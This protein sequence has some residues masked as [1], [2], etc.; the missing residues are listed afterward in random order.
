MTE[1][2]Y[3]KKALPF[4]IVDFKGQCAYC[5]DSK[6]FRAPSQSQVEHFDCKLSGRQRHYYRN[7]NLS[8]AACN[9]SKHD[10]PVK[11]PFNPEQRLLNCCEENEYIGHIIEDDRGQW[12]PVTEAGKYHLAC[13]NL[14]ADCHVK[15]RNARKVM[16]ERIHS[17]LTTAI[18]YQTA[19]PQEVHDQLMGTVRDLMDHLNNFPP[20]VTKTGILTTKEWLVSR[21]VDVNLL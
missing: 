15:K 8:C 1:A 6:E 14:G 21:G 16:V 9:L 18:Q 19:N 11:N 12:L 4:L 10:K 3:R 2:T 20:I 17:L 7:L 5:L 13:I